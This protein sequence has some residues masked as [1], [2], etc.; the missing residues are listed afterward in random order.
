MIKNTVSV[1]KNSPNEINS[2]I[3]TAE[4]K[5]SKKRKYPKLNTEGKKG[6]N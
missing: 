3:D 6:K 1:M 2:K 5:V 4:E